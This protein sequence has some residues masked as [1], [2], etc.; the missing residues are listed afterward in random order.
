M[1]TFSCF[2]SKKSHN[3]GLKVKP[4]RMLGSREKDTCGSGISLIG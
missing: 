3:A 1:I 2:N 4:R